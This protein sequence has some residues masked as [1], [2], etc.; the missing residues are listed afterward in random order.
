MKE[1]REKTHRRPEDELKVDVLLPLQR[2]VALPNRVRHTIQQRRLVLVYR[3]IRREVLHSSVDAVHD[4]GGSSIQSV[5]VG[6]G[7]GESG[8]REEPD[9]YETGSEGSITVLEKQG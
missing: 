2:P 5:Q 6:D 3:R 4:E 1:P 7:D 9:S 8:V